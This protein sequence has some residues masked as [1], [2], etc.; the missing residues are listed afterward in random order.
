M[1]DKKDKGNGVFHVFI[2]KTK[3]ETEASVL[4][5][6]QILDLASMSPNDYDLFLVKGQGESERINPDQDVPIQNGLHF[7]A[8]AKGVNFGDPART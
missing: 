1:T 3:Y 8:I 7:N 5:G 2:N 6:S 4:K